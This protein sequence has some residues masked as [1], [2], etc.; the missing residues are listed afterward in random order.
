MIRVKGTT[1]KREREKKRNDK[2]TMLQ[3]E[4]E[5]MQERGEDERKRRRHWHD[6]KGE[7]EREVYEEK[8]QARESIQ[9]VSFGLGVIW[10]VRSVH[11]MQVTQSHAVFLSR[12]L[13]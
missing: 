12:A 3:D 11:A 8:E 7:R 13:N 9:P 5:M 1:V 2:Y 6:E 4:S 10:C